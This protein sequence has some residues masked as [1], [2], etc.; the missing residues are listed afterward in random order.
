MSS[1]G[2]EVTLSW[3]LQCPSWLRYAVEEQEEEEEEEE[4]M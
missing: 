2:G 4:M 1:G 3:S